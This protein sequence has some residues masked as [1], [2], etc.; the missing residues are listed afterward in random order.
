[1]R[2]T[3]LYGSLW[4]G[5]NGLEPSP[6]WIDFLIKIDPKIIGLAINRIVLSG[7]KYP[8]HLPEFLGICQSAAGFPDPAQAYRDAAH[9]K[10]SHP[11]V[12]E[13]ANR[14]GHFELRTGSEREMLPKWE[15]VYK[16]VCCEAMAGKNFARPDFVK[17]DTPKIVPAR[18]DF[19]ENKLS[20]INKILGGY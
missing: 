6:L 19:V 12:Y 14:I 7:Q 3:E 4:T 5:Q 15:N 2:M 1:M 11:T 8:P 17:I 16:Q 13:T 10:W 20:E 18:P 9:K